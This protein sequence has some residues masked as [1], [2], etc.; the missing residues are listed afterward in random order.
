L[1]VKTVQVVE[2]VFILFIAVNVYGSYRYQMDVT[3]GVI[4]VGLC[5]DILE[6]YTGAMYNIVGRF[7]DRIKLFL[8]GRKKYNRIKE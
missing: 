2:V 5:G 6:V 4:A 8:I 3:Y 1:V 7:R